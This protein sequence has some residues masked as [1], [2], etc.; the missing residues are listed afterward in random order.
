MIWTMINVPEFL[1]A[2]YGKCTLYYIHL[3]REENE[4][5]EFSNAMLVTIL[6]FVGGWCN[7]DQLH[8]AAVE[9]RQE[10]LIRV[11]FRIELVYAV[12][13]VY[14]FV[15]RIL[16]LILVLVLSILRNLVVDRIHPNGGFHQGQLAKLSYV[17]GLIWW[18][19]VKCECYLCCTP[20]QVAI[21]FSCSLEFECLQRS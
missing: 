4:C 16:I 21:L 14:P 15:W 8:V 5:E 3:S 9:S 13:I 20:F 17:Y 7:V 18:Y 11:F 1:N 10:N 19:L 12:E 2:W 6:I